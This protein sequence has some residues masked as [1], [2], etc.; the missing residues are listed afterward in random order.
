MP[1]TILLYPRIAGKPARRVA[2]AMNIPAR[3]HPP[4]TR[5]DVLIRYGNAERI[6]FAPRFTINTREAILGNANKLRSL[7]IMSEA[8]VSVPPF[9]ITTHGLSYPI[10]GR[11]LSHFGGRDIRFYDAPE[12]VAMWPSDFY[13][14]FIPKQREYRVHVAFGQI[15]KYNKKVY[16]EGRVQRRDPRIWNA[17][18]GYRFVRTPY[19]RRFESAVDAVQSLGLDFGAVDMILSTDNTMYVLEINTAPGNK[20][21]SLTVQAYADAL[22]ARIRELMQ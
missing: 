13:V 9:G 7:Q 15:I 19:R 14:Q 4:N 5:V 20:G 2:T 21:S 12:E 17:R 10:V 18:N 1:N 16:T 11:S 22:N 6:R 3:R 8:G